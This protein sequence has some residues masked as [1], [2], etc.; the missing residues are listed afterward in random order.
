M[1][2]RV[3]FV[4]V[5]KN[6]PA[7]QMNSHKKSFPLQAHEVVRV[8]DIVLEV[9]DARF[10]DD[11]RNLEIEKEILGKGKKIIYVLNKADLVD[12]SELIKS[13]K[14]KD[15]KPYVLVSCKTNIGRC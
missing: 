1:G 4:G 13:G 9:L 2:A 11:T 14:L 7:D 3:R 15:L 6:I 12:T 10:I 5:G 8:S